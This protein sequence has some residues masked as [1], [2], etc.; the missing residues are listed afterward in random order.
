[1]IEIQSAII[2]EKV[3]TFMIIRIRIM[4]MKI[5]III[6]IMITMKFVNVMNQF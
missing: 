6:I 1:M 4:I 3:S 5:I 2:V